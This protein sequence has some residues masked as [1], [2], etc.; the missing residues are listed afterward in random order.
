MEPPDPTDPNQPPPPLRPPLDDEPPFERPQSN[1]ALGLTRQNVTIGDLISKAS[2]AWRR[3]L[4]TWVLATVLWVLIGFGIPFV[5]G[6]MVGFLG[7]LLSGG[8]APPAAEAVMTGLNIGVQILQTVIQGVLGMGFWA[9]A[10]HG[11]HGGPAPIG[12]LFGQIHK[13]LKYILQVLA[14]WV[15]IALL[16]G[17]IGAAV[18]FLSVGSIDLDMPL[19]EAFTEAAPAL[20]VFFLVATPIYAYILLGIVFAQIELTYN[21]S[22]GPIE[23]VLYSWKIAHKRRWLILGVSLIAGLIAVG[24]ML[25]CGI[26][27][28]FGGPLA[29]L[30]IAALYLALREGAD[31]PAPDTGSTLGKQY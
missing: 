16:F 26:G 30:I 27:F 7:A 29:T 11:L 1:P 15:P 21:D 2:D 3:D 20:W 19:E 9:M 24:S 18:F 10:I 13:A 4:G 22:A 6:L 25:L 17:A 14:I 31:V 8:D 5:L 23:A 28:L 12:A